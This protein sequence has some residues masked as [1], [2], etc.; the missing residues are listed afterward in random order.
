MTVARLPGQ[1]GD[2][3]FLVPAGAVRA[4][5]VRAGVIGAA[6]ADLS[7]AVDGD[8]PRRMRHL[9][10]RSF[11]PL[12]EHS[13]GSVGQL[14]AA[15]VGELV[16]P[17]DK[18]V[19]GVGA[20]MMLVSASAASRAGWPDPARPGGRCRPP[21]RRNGL[22]C[23]GYPFRSGSFD[24]SGPNEA[25]FPVPVRH[26][27]GPAGVIDA[28]VVEGGDGGDRGPR[29]WRTSPGPDKVPAVTAWLR[30]TLLRTGA[31]ASPRCQRAGLLVRYRRRQVMI[32]G[33][34]G[35]GRA[36]PL[37]AWLVSDRRQPTAR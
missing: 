12:A 16:Q 30:L 20:A 13:P 37:A 6:L 22:G 4:G 9:P 27:R 21:S 8:L 32:D 23:A 34:P 15:A 3:R 25:G 33:G 29:P 31:M 24:L 1:L 10:Q 17:G 11:L 28:Q 35:T 18:V 14:E 7:T 2:V 5:E 26:E 36:G 19:A